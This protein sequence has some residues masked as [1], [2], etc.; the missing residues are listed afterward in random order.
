[1]HLY[2]HAAT[3]R[4]AAQEIARVDFTRFPDYSGAMTLPS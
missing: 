1:M 3:M 4:Y 2:V